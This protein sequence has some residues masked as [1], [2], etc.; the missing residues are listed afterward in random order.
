MSGPSSRLVPV[1]PDP[2]ASRL[3]TSRSIR[4][5]RSTEPVA[6]YP[7]G[8]I[9]DRLMQLSC[10]RRVV[11]PFGG[12]CSSEGI[13][14]V[15]EGLEIDKHTGHTLGVFRTASIH[16]EMQLNTGRSHPVTDSAND[17]HETCK[18][19]TKRRLHLVRSVLSPLCIRLSTTYP[20]PT[21]RTETQ[22]QTDSCGCGSRSASDQSPA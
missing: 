19:D 7:A 2:V 10:L 5:R 21:P 16:H 15:R 14:A 8:L 3:K 22:R 11:P 12:L 9:R 13:P 4:Y 17:S 18:T 1:P 6:T 20:F